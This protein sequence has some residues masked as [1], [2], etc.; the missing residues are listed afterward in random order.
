MKK[1]IN[2]F[3]VLS[4]LFAVSIFTSCDIPEAESNLWCEKAIT[5]DIGDDTYDLTC[6]LMY[7]DNYKSSKAVLEGIEFKDGWNF[8]IVPSTTS[9]SQVTEFFLKDK[10]VF[11]NFS[12]SK[13]ISNDGEKDEE[14]DDLFSF[15]FT[16]DA[17][18][19]FVLL[20]ASELDDNGWSK[21]P[22]KEIQNTSDYTELTDFSEFSWKKVL[23]NYLLDTVLKEEE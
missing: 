12:G 13:L 9:D 5:Y 4:I 18:D 20:N 11:K 15:N 1:L 22:P 19:L 17:F 2:I 16:K 10:Y 14:D 7:A 8:V 23:A 21:N 3:A 6:Y